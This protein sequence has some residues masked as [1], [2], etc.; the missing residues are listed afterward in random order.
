MLLAP[1]DTAMLQTLASELQQ[2][3]QKFMDSLPVVSAI[4][5][6]IGQEKPP[7]CGG[8]DASLCEMFTKDS[9]ISNG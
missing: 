6:Q 2:T 7:S 8:G 1:L 9:M 3:V 5:P 4:T